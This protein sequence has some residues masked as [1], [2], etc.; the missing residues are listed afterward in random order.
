MFNGMIYNFQQLKSDFSNQ[1][2]NSKSDTEVILKSYLKYGIDLDSEKLNKYID[3]YEKTIFSDDMLK[4]INDKSVDFIAIA[5]PPET[6]FEIAKISLNNKKNILITKPL[7]LN[8]SEANE[9][10]E[11]S[12][13]KNCNVYIDETFIFSNQV[14]ELKKIIKNKK[15]FGD[16]T[17]INSNRV[18]L[19]LFQQKT[20]VIWDLAPH[21]IAIT[22]YILEEYPKKVRSTAINPFKDK[23]LY[24]SY[25]NC[26]YHFLNHDI[27][28]TSQ[29]SWLSPVKTRRMVF[30]GTKQ[31]VIYDH[32]DLEAPLK[33]FNQQLK[34]E[35]TIVISEK[36]GI[37]KSSQELSESDK[38]IIKNMISKLSIKEI[39]NLIHS[40]NKV[41]KKK[42]YNYCLKL[43]NEN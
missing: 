14:I 43:K 42:I 17:F 24:E 15:E 13:K 1:K 32:L 6:H 35:L 22:S 16:L 20:N 18:N 19:G 10:L 33:V 38:R 36:K 39:T 31:T 41:S 30:G 5:T 26:E 37:K 21:D 11:I 4:P 8:I 25:A 3:I 2:F 7:C 40:N 27:L 28:F 29:I 9:L 34:G 23:M 12:K